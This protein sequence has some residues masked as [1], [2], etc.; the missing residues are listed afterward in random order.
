MARNSTPGD[1]PLVSGSK[2]LSRCRGAP[3]AIAASDSAT[4]RC[5]IGAVDRES[6]VA[7]PMSAGPSPLMSPPAK[8][9]CGR[10]R[11]R[12]V[13]SIAWVEKGGASRAAAASAA[14]MSASPR[15]RFHR[16]SARRGSRRSMPIGS[17]APS[18]CDSRPAEGPAGAGARGRNCQGVRANTGRGASCAT[19]V[20]GERSCSGPS[21][22][23]RS[24]S[25]RSCSG[26]SC[27]DCPGMVPISTCLQLQ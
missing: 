24:C 11:R 27:S 14:G 7:G 8:A 25:G 3:A 13:T 20:A 23:G 2:S 1:G 4:R 19:G 16:C 18:V 26:R 10:P 5:G 17:A 15:S 9:I 22:S 12:C 21:C 6:P